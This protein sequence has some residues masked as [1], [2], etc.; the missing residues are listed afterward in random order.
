M[1]EERSLSDVGARV[2]QLLTELGSV[3]DPR[4]Q[5]K[6]EEAVRLLMQLYGGALARIVDII[7]EEESGGHL[8]DRLVG[9]DLVGSLLVLH[10]LHPRDTATRVREALDRVRPYL[11]SH[12]GG[13]ELLGVADGIVYLRL[14]GSCDG[15]PSSAVTVKLA[16][17]RA[18]EE[19]APE[20]TSV[21]VEG[22]TEP[23][24][25]KERDPGIIPVESLFQRPGA[26]GTGQAGELRWSSL[27]GI[28]GLRQGELRGVEVDG[29]SVVVCNADGTLYAYRDACPSCGTGV[30][31]GRLSGKVLTCP[32]CG[33]EYDVRL[34]G[35][36]A[37]TRDVHLDPL[38]LLTE[39]DEV[40][41]AVVAGAG[42]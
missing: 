30:A 27:P 34:A 36:S 9:D 22:M 23:S 24:S 2:E 12:A 28:D 19:A 33:R 39:G 8:L 38:P 17:E 15:C 42:S 4:V 14:E 10:D 35:R 31:Q 16:I 6:T 1:S 3:G 7:A 29:A 11:G 20:V 32:A 40:R 37:E 21:E 26:D 18:I 25:G 5:E 13:V 41:I